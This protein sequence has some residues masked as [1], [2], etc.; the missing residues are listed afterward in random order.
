MSAMEKDNMTEV[1]L[2]YELAGYLEFHGESTAAD[3]VVQYAK[4]HHNND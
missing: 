4:Q 1:Q 3:M 2:A